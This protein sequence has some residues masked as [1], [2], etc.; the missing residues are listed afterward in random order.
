MLN[1]FLYVLFFILICVL[2]FRLKGNLKSLAIIL[3]SYGFYYYWCGTLLWTLI[4]VS[5][6]SYFGAKL[7]EK[8]PSSKFLLYITSAILVLVPLAV[9][10][11]YLPYVS[12]AGNQ[13]NGYMF[14]FGLKKISE[15]HY[16][17]PIGMSYFTFQALG[18]VM[19]VYRKRITA[20]KNILHFFSFIA[21]FPQLLIGPIEKYSR[22]NREL[23]A[24]NKFKERMALDGVLL[25]F[26][27]LIKK[28]V[29]S[30]NIAP[31]VESLFNGH[32]PQEQYILAIL[33]ALLYLYFDFSSYSDIARG[34][35]KMLNIEIMRNFESP[36]SKKSVG[37]FWSSWHI[38]LHHWLRDNVLFALYKV[39]TKKFS[40]YIWVIF[41]FLLC[42]IWHGPEPKFLIVTFFAAMFVISEHILKD[43][44]RRK[45]ITIKFPGMSILL[46]IYT[47]TVMSCVVLLLIAPNFKRY[48]EIISS[49]EFIHFKTM[50]ES[51]SFLSPL[52]VYAYIGATIIIVLEHYRQKIK[53]YLG[54]KSDNLSFAIVVPLIILVMLF[55]KTSFR[56]FIYFFS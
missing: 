42:G 43:I 36:I 41:T 44:L 18:Y 7:I 31:I 45:N 4:F 32:L 16:V 48:Y 10:K 29:I 50:F 46:H 17:I 30:D 19:D 28:V 22:L 13:V 51:F 25:V 14:Y 53:K 38:S 47:Y 20:S 40:I 1:E 23:T 11:Y 12:L 6:C 35:S 3:C 9:Y 15:S 55:Y 49:V 39:S 27:G 52:Q 5:I 26:L 2:L 24:S 33:S 54:T 8:H 56:P 34:I 37:S 21:Y